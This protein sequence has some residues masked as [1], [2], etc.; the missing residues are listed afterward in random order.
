FTIKN[1][2]VKI[3]THMEVLITG[4][5]GFLGL[6]IARYFSQKKWDIRLL[7]I[8][9]FPK[10]EY[11]KGTEYIQGY[12]RDKKKV[13]EAVTGC[14]VI[15]HAAAALPLRSREEIISTNVDGTRNVLSEAVKQKVSRVVYI[16][17]TAVYGVP[18]KHPVYET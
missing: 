10:E 1:S 17:S 5:A 13:E 9:P 12:V 11:P 14:H 18:E 15:I 2:S 8:A 7:D 4:G 6:H 16:S 3:T